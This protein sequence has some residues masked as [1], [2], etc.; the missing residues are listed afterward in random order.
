[1]K[2]EPTQQIKTSKMKSHSPLTMTYP[3]VQR[4][5]KA[6]AL[7]IYQTLQTLYSEEGTWN[8]GWFAAQRDG[9]SCSFA[10][11]DAVSFD[12]IGAIGRICLALKDREVPPRL[13]SRAQSLVTWSLIDA[14]WRSGED[15]PHIKSPLV[16][17]NDNVC[18]SRFDA[19]Q[20]VQSG[21]KLL[22]EKV[23][24]H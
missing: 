16:N 3:F 5:E 4:K 6:L 22:Q 14:V 7:E 17:W 13:V 24:V 11:K 12:L 21:Q 2:P 20:M 15:T 10:S 1:M 18:T 8:S 9:R 23:E 19:L